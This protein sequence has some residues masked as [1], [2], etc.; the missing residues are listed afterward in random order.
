MN[1][2]VEQLVLARIPGAQITFT[3]FKNDNRHFVLQVTSDKFK[4][5]QLV[6]Q[7]RAVMSAIKE[8]IDSGEL[9]AVKIV[10]KILTP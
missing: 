7:H 6:D 5:M 1:K 8:L 10:T 2:K 9:H 4:N 3:D